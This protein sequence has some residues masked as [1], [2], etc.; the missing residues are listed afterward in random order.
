MSQRARKPLIFVFVLG[1]VVLGEAMIYT[2]GGREIFARHE[3]FLLY[4]ND[5]VSGLGPGS[6]VK[7]KGVP[8]GT[9]QTVR[10]SFQTATG[11]RRVPVVIQ[12]NSDR[13][14]NQL[15]VLEDLSDP[16]VLAGQVRRGLRAELH[17]ESYATGG[18]Y[19]GLDYNPHAPP[20]AALPAA[21]DWPIIPT[22][23]SA[24]VTR[25]QKIQDVIAWLPTYDFRA[26]ITQA[27]DA[28]DSL[29][30]TV[31]V[32]PF[33]E[34]HQKIVDAFA[35][36]TQINTGA[37]PQKLST[38]L[39]RLDVIL[40]KITLANN[41]FAASS[42]S[43]SALNQQSQAQ[44][45]QVDD[46]LAAFRDDLRPEAPWLDHFTHNLQQLQGDMQRLTEKTNA[47]EDNPRLF[48][49]PAK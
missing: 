35:P 25:L 32:I 29:R 17:I 37:W 24:V 11:D 43:F 6:L 20:P 19:V 10:L 1:A 41:D 28:L 21:S 48:A 46:F 49:K 36:L 45:R 18:M 23:P 5:T 16:E 27:G 40:D 4:F 13:L 15:G 2:F 3:S 44:L 39:G 34:Y 42:Q 14:Q 47:F 7:F 8:I 12:L 33:A 22:V 26:K 31:S 30:T 9:V 38:F